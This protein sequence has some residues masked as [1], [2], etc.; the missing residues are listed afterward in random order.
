MVTMT[1]KSFVPQAAKSVSQALMS[2]MTVND[3]SQRLESAGQPAA[4]STVAGGDY[5]GSAPRL[6][7]AELKD[8][9]QCINRVLTI[10]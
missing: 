5:Y 10:R 3:E 4:F 2:D 8:I 7:E 6:I 1:Q 9:F